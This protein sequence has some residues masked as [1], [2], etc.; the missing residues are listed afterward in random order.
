[1][2]AVLSVGSERSTRSE[3]WTLEV[4][5]ELVEQLIDTRGAAYR[6]PGAHTGRPKWWKQDARNKYWT[7][8]ANPGRSEH[9]LDTRSNPG[10]PERILDARSGGNWTPGAN[11]GHRS[12]Y[13][14][15]GAPTGRPEHLLDA[16]STYWTPEGDPSE[17]VYWQTLIITSFTTSY[18]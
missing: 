5:A 1:M 10:R 16:R 9:I 6:T 13:W 8:G 17:K 2:N 14:T 18:I 3:E 4:S 12:K 11:T 7:P 15:P